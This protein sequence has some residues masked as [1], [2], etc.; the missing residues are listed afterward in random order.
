MLETLLIILVVALVLCF[1]GFCIAACVLLW[2]M[3]FLLI[4]AGLRS[5]FTG[6][7]RPT[8]RSWRDVLGV[9]R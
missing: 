5:I 7:K 1:L 8:G 6:T 9:A 2:R 3:I 4:A